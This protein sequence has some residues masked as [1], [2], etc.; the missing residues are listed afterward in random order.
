MFLSNPSLL[1]TSFPLIFEVKNFLKFFSIN[2]SETYDPLSMLISDS[3]PG[4]LIKTNGLLVLHLQF[5]I[6]QKILHS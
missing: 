5:Q 2:S 4:L 6:C 3:P 1:F